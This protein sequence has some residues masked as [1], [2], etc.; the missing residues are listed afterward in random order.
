MGIPWLTIKEPQPYIRPRKTSVRKS[1]P[2]KVEPTKFDVKLPFLQNTNVKFTDNEIDMIKESAMPPNA[3][4]SLTKSPSRLEQ[5]KM[6]HFDS[7]AKPLEMGLP[8]STYF[9]L[10]T[11]SSVETETDDIDLI[12]LNGDEDDVDVAKIDPLPSSREYDNEFQRTIKNESNTCDDSITEL[13]NQIW[14]YCHNSDDKQAK[15]PAFLYDFEITNENAI[16]HMSRGKKR[17]L[18][19]IDDA[20]PESTYE[21]TTARK[22]SQSMLTERSF[23][24]RKMK[25][26]FDKRNMWQ[27]PFFDPPMQTQRRASRYLLA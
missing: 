20:A 5:I 13:Q 10:Q 9:T 21:Q 7:A 2:V 25:D 19:A 16:P 15:R 1:A 3:G 22:H 11:Q 6:T 12:S 24:A 18:A 23:C 17:L 8:N 27:P 4:G 26:Y 14:I